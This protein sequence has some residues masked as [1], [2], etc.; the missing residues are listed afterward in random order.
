M[1]I[2]FLSPP[3]NLSGG[4]RVIAIY[5]RELAARGHDVSVVC[6]GFKQF[7][8][9]QRVRAFVK[10]RKWLKQPRL[11]ESHYRNYGIK[12]SVVSHDG[13]LT[14]SDLPDA[15]VVIATFWPT[16]E[17]TFRLNV[18]KGRKF[19]LVQHDEGTIHENAGADLTYDLPLRHVYV[20]GWIANRIRSRH[21]YAEGIVVNNAI[22]VSE[23]KSHCRCKPKEVQFGMMWAGDDI[24][25]GDI[26]IKA[27][28]LVRSLGHKVKLVAFG[29]S[30][31]PR[32]YHKEID[33]FFLQPDSETMASIY[34]SCTAWLFTSRFEGFGL[35]ILESMASRTPVIATPTGAAPELIRGGSGILLDS[36][37]VEAVMGALI[38][39]KEMSQQ[40][41]QGFSIQAFNTAM[42]CNWSDSTTALEEYIMDIQ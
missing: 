32:E 33:S 27:I 21:P 24:K 7:T 11:G 16:A 6:S 23:F 35:P 13:P 17:W 37:S 42:R 29:V 26:A 22:D 10:E 5:A 36:F 34:A 25:G 8:F 28:Q 41:W 30:E 3:P 14:D 2:T 39:F 4:E 40:E 20:S 31:P 15:D 38:K 18:N 12:Y 9:S 1:N 19:Y